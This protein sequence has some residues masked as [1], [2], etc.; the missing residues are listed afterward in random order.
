MPDMSFT[1]KQA[2]YKIEGSIA[3]LVKEEVWEKLLKGEV[4]GVIEPD[5]ERYSLFINGQFVRAIRAKT[6]TRLKIKAEVATMMWRA[7]P[8][9]I[10]KDIEI[11]SGYPNMIQLPAEKV[12]K[13]AEKGFD[14]RRCA[15]WVRDFLK[16]SCGKIDSLAGVFCFMEEIHNGMERQGRD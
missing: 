7:L 1:P 9:N 13:Y 2:I 5:P 16:R 3:A 12:K 14:A 8:G 11:T 6:E 4:V 10:V 15:E